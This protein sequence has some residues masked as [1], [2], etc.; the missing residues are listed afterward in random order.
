MITKTHTNQEQGTSMFDEIISNILEQIEQLFEE[1]ISN[2]TIVNTLLEY[3]PNM[4][5][6]NKIL[7]IWDGKKYKAFSGIHEEQAFVLNA[8]KRISGKA[9]IS[10]K[11]IQDIH[12]DILTNCYFKP[13]VT[14]DGINRLNL[15]NGILEIHSDG[16]CKLEKHN[17]KF[18]FPYVATY[19]YNKTE[20][21][22]I[23]QRILE[24][25][26]EEPE[27][28]M[29]FQ[30]FLGYSLIQGDYRFEKS[31]ILL[32]NGRNGKSVILSVIKK[33][34]C[35]ENITHFEINQLTDEKNILMMEN[36]MLNIGSDSSRKGLDG[37][38]LKKLISGETVKG[39]A[40]YQNPR[41]INNLPK[42]MF[43]MNSLP[44]AKGDT[45]F[46]FIRRFLIVKFEKTIPEDQVNLNLA[47]ELEGELSGI[48]NFAIEGALRLVAQKRFTY[49]DKIN[50]AI[51]AYQS[52]INPVQCFVD[53][54]GIKHN[55]NGRITHEQLFL[56]YKTWC[57]KEGNQARNKRYLIH[58]LDRLGF[59][60][61]KNNTDRG[62]RVEIT[63]FEKEKRGN[64][65]KAIARK[66]VR[67]LLSDNEEED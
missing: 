54:C 66:S 21:C 24:E 31:L 12:A 15:D 25:T 27:A 7:Y 8:A 13:T 36:K 4:I 67:E 62:F 38:H 64:Q 28:I 19:P 52:D 29:V 34:L 41:F 42:L 47:N 57:D 35:E 44:L 26:I 59:Q 14:K 20:Q 51:Q 1:K 58:E 43:A 33:L 39:R 17:K 2:E 6:I 50:A 5:A 53:D 23:F 32:G 37:D 11:R 48:L 22:P 40:L 65:L 30:E 3:S 55:E 9:S 49:S 10:N 45:S 16:R 63:E 60:K 56:I 46:G 18:G 61:Y